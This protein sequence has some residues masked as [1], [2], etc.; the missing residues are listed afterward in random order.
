MWTYNKGSALSENSPL[1]YS[2]VRIKDNHSIGCAVY[3][4]MLQLARIQ[5]IVR[6][7]R[8]YFVAVS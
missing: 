1:Q 3:L 6:D 2:V 5:F 4:V 8:C 7:V